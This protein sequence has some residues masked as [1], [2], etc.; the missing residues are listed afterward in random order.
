MDKPSTNNKESMSKSRTCYSKRPPQSSCVLLALLQLHAAHT[1]D[2]THQE[3][4]LSDEV[5]AAQILNTEKNSR[6][7]FKLFH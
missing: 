6:K 1:D 7:H 2:L 5:T 3:E 4:P